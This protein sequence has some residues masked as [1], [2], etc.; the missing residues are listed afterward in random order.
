MPVSALWKVTRSTVPARVCSGVEA[1]ARWSRRLEPFRVFA[2]MVR[3]DA[4]FRPGSA[5]CRQRSGTR[6]QGRGGTHEW[7]QA[8]QTGRNRTGVLAVSARLCVVSSDTVSKL[9]GF[10]DGA[11]RLKSF[12]GAKN[13]HVAIVE[14]APQD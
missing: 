11:K 13:R 9:D 8:F 14:H 12:A 1:G 2:D 10:A 6:S 5:H 7:D 4:T 3:V